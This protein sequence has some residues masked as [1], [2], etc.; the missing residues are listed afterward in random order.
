MIDK[1]MSKDLIIGDINNTIFDIATLMKKYD[2]GFIPI[3]EKNKIKGVITDR[4]I[5]VKCLAN[6]E[7]NIIKDYIN[8]KVI[9]LPVYSSINDVLNVMKQEKVKR[10][11]INDNKK[12]VG[13][14]S[15]SDIINNANYDEDLIKTL[16][17]I[18]KI[19]KNND[20]YSTEIDEFYL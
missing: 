13:I 9:S 14:I 8:K 16:K 19:K 10:I 3:A 4:D 17:C 15:I 12:I 6:N 11:I 5:V 7:N 18:Y 1:I 20:N 2:I